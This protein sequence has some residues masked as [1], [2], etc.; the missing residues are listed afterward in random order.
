MGLISILSTNWAVMREISRQEIILGKKKN[1][2][3]VTN[4]RQLRVKCKRYFCAMLYA[5]PP[6]PTPFVLV[7]WF[8]SYQVLVMGCGF[9][10]AVEH[11]PWNHEVEVKISLAV[12]LYTAILRTPLYEKTYSWNMGRSIKITQFIVSGSI[13]SCL[14]WLTGEKK[15]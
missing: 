3:R 4:Q 12:G 14:L 1:L 8:K 10:S 5:A 11:L 9:S 7:N 13:F 15:L 2:S 6:S